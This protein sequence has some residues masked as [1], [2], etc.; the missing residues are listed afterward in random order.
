MKWD[1]FEKIIKKL[2]DTT[3]SVHQYYTADKPEKNKIHLCHHQ[4]SR[5]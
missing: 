2:D 5:C 4:V 3:N 1:V